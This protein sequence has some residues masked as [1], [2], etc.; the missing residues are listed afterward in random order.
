MGMGGN[1]GLQPLPS[2]PIQFSLDDFQALV[3]KQ[4]SITK[5]TY[6]VLQDFD[7]DIDNIADAIENSENPSQNEQT[8]NFLRSHGLG[9]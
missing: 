9:A 4:K 8:V 1:N 3:D 5:S 6:L 7:D 2:L